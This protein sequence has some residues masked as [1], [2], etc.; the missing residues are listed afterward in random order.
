LPQHYSLFLVDVFVF[1]FLLTQNFGHVNRCHCIDWF[2]PF[3]R[4]Q[5]KLNSTCLWLLFSC[6]ATFC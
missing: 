4:E 1:I 2:A 3:S 5:V 6:E